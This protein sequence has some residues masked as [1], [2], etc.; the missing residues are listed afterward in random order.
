MS[1][2]EQARAAVTEPTEATVGRAALK[3]WVKPRVQVGGVAAQTEGAHGAGS[4]A[5]HC[6]S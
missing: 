6:L 4:D 5:S 1:D 3:P 2:V